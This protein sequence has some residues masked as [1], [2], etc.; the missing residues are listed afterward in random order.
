MR[1]L[2]VKIE[3]TALGDSIGAMPAVSEFQK[4]E[5]CNVHVLTKWKRILKN[6]YPNLIFE[7]AKADY[8]QIFSINYH[9]DQPLQLGFARDLGFIDWNYIRP[10]VDFTPKARPVN[11]K[12]VAIG[13]QSTAQCKYWNYPNAWNILCNM[14]RK[15]G[16]IPVC[17]DQYKLFGVKGKMNEVP[18]IAMK[19]LNNS[20][21][22]SMNYIY[23][24]EFFIGISSGLSWIAHALGKK[25]VMISGT[26][27]PWNEFSE[28]C[29][30]IINRDVCHGC[31]HE[32]EKYK[33]DTGDWMW[34]PEHKNT[35]RHFECTAT[36]APDFVMEKMKQGKLI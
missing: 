27:L 31:F 2:L 19:K 15:E 7:E 36:I 6:S 1:N 29:V 9:F 17:I 34:C 10:K 3:T 30:R 25:V 26:T 20:I 11:S 33:F 8:D 22:V 21:E 14:L 24:A 28:D 18:K 5:N 16:L 23:H 35:T 12:Y 13:I 32:I 4:R